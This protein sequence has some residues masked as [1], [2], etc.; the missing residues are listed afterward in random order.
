VFGLFK[1]KPPPPERP[2]ERFPPVPDWKPNIIQPLDLIVERVRH[3]TNGT[4]DFAVFTNGT[5]A[6]LPTGLDENRAKV[7]AKEALQRVFH[8]HPD[9]NPLNMKDGNV[10]VQY[11]HDVATVVL[12][13]ITEANWQA[14]E[15]NHQR[16]LATHEVLITPLG[17]NVFDQFGKK[18][19][20][21]RCFMFMDAQSPEVVRVE[22]SVA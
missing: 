17:H 16:A 20:F 18:A 22:R 6:V 2:P 13:E 1:K 15:D 19:L 3:Y 21:G 12:S 14:I 4:R 10:L 9:M 7:H 5:V 8:A 11:N